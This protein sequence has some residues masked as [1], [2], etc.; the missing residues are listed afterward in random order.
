MKMNFDPTKHNPD[1]AYLRSLIE[2]A[3]MTQAEAARQLGIGSRQMRYYL[4][5]EKKYAMPYTL[6]FCLETI[7]RQNSQPVISICADATV[8]SD[9]VQ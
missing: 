3:G 5:P 7:T 9:C 8:L 1:P 2:K 4:S 6:Q